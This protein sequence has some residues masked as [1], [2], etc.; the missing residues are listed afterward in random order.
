MSGAINLNN[1]AIIILKNL[2][3]LRGAVAKI[4][5]DQTNADL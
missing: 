4:Y 5:V 3:G 2:L 1:N